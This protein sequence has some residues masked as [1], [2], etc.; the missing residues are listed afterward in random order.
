MKI[1]YRFL[2]GCMILRLLVLF[3]KG[4]LNQKE[5]KENQKQTVCKYLLCKTFPKT[6]ESFFTYKIDNNWYRNSYRHC[7]KDSEKK[8][9]KYFR[10]YYSSKD[11]S[12]IVV[13]FSKEV[14]DSTEIVN[15][16][17]SLNKL[18]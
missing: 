13:D 12:K 5:I 2:L 18:E 3:V 6:T 17:F 7:S 11:F 15:A 16:G 14:T 4:Y 10:V 9:N 8:I 1:F